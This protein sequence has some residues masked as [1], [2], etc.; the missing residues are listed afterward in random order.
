MH[1]KGSRYRAHPTA[2]RLAWAALAAC[3]AFAA[4]DAVSRFRHPHWVRRADGAVMLS[5]GT[6][7]V[8]AI[9]DDSAS[10]IQPAPGLAWERL[11]SGYGIGSSGVPDAKMVLPCLKINRDR[12]TGVLQWSVT[13]VTLS[14]LWSMLA[15]VAVAGLFLT[16]RFRAGPCPRCGYSLAGLP[17]D[18]PRCPECG[19]APPQPSAAA[20]T[21]P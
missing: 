17:A 12:G 19:G 9:H 14:W 8:I 10:V 21:P 18:N 13:T 16:R 2:R 3:V 4:T 11:P 1:V 7:T 6:L 15:I 5:R 20:T